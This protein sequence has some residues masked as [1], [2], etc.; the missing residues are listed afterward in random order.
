[1]I[2]RCLISIILA[3]ALAGC[4]RDGSAATLN[5]PIQLAPGQSAAFKAE[6]LEVTFVGIASDS[7]CP[8]DVT[9]VW[10]GELVVRIAIRS[11]GRQT[12]HELKEMQQATVDGYV[13]NLL[14]V[15][16]ARG[17]QEQRIAPNDYRV[18]LKV[19]RADAQAN[20]R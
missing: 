8:S 1:M 10:A 2:A 4:G 3:V 7:R 14:E 17:P 9:C 18:T 16:P 6:Q 12:E 19:T 15:L 13:V 5:A 11:D 20:S